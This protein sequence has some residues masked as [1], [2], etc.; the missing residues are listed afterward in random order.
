[1]FHP[2]S[3]QQ[4]T[5]IFILVPVFFLLTLSGIFGY[6]GMR[7][8]LIEQWSETALS[9]LGRAAHT[10]DMRLNRPKQLL[11][12]LK[13]LNNNGSDGAVRKR[14][15]DQLGKI[16]GVVSVK[17]D[18]PESS[19]NQGNW[20]AYKRMNDN[21]NWQ[22]MSDQGTWSD[23]DEIFAITDPTYNIEHS[24]TTFSLISRI[25]N[26]KN[27]L[28]G[29][30]EIVIDYES[31]TAGTIQ[32]P[33]WN[34]YKAYIIHL[35]GHVLTGV[36]NEENSISDHRP[37]LFGAAD[38]LEQ[39]TLEALKIKE[40]G[41]VFGPGRPP[42]EISGF[43][44]LKGAPW[45]LVVIAPGKKVLQPILHFR[46]VYILTAVLCIGGIL[47]FIRFM[48]SKTTQSIKKVSH[49]ASDLA[50]GIFNEPL[51]VNSRDEVG[52]LTR[53]FNTMTRQLKKGFQLQKAMDIAREVQLTLLP[54]NDFS[55]Q[56]VK[57]SGLSIYCDETGGD[58]FDF[59]EPGYHSSKLFAV[60]GDVV[61]HGIGAALLMATLR[62]SVRARSEQEESLHQL[63]GAVNR[64]LCCDTIGQGNFAS[65]FFLSIDNS[66]KE[67]QWVRAGHDPAFLYHPLRKEFTELKGNGLILG[68]DS[69][70][71]YQT[72]RLAFNDDKYVIL[73]Y[74]DGAWE[75]E[76]KQGEQFGKHRLRESVAA[77][78]HLS[79]VDI[80]QSLTESI[81]EFRGDA[82]LRDD[83]TLVVITIDGAAP[84]LEASGT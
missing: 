50:R 37:N 38:L 55:G 74:S 52:E 81:H 35:D 68:V 27:E 7:K 41:T 60:V 75:I 14:I 12:L 83:I 64:Q 70:Y 19:M 5:V 57:M 36:V 2:K 15:I 71:E 25:V 10:I 80:L 84:A 73:V 8:V 31:L 6:H 63:I 16:D 20:S 30:I 72:S 34:I 56:G 24:S 78:S 79:P 18:W 17:V 58:Y 11:F 54:Q 3:L 44:R 33:W 65:L 9:K 42:E 23:A 66:K 45:S 29:T 4:R 47:L 1:M 13:G 76:N 49:T 28:I 26:D 61:G 59:I 46:N 82:V 22:Q 62:S 48:I 39:K 67:L 40:S 21:Y 32:T 69:N 51:M 53:N 43:Y 77:N